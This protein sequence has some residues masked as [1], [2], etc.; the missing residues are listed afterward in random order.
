MA[1]TRNLSLSAYA[2]G[3]GFGFVRERRP[4]ALAVQSLDL[5]DLVGMCLEHELDGVEFPVDRY[6]PDLSLGA[7]ERFVEQSQASNLRVIFDLERFSATYFCE[8]APIVRRY[9]G[10]FVRAKVCNFYGGNRFREP[11]YVSEKA[12]FLHELSGCVEAID[13]YGVRVLVENHQDVTAKD[14]IGFSEEFGSHRVGVNWDTGNS[15]PSGET[16]A[17]FL[18]KTIHLIGNVHLKDYR[19]SSSAGGYVM[20]RCALGRGVVDFERFVPQLVDYSRGRIPFTIE[21]GAMTGREALI[22]DDRYWVHTEGVSPSEIDSLQRFVRSHLE[23][24]VDLR[25]MWEQSAPPS[26]IAKAELEEVQES[27]TYC[28]GLFDGLRKPGSF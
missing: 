13:R 25:S 18:E 3:Y 23:D 21:L 2:F 5:L 1:A 24:H 9:G 16:T 17:S 4:N 22:G 19:F 27:V 7:L 20:H 28:K 10:E 6:F 15:F 26:E 12:A 8:L 14:L 11:S